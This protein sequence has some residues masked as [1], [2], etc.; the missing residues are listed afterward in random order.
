[1]IAAAAL[2]AWAW[3]LT[4]HGRFWQSGPALPPMLPR[5]APDGAPD[6]AIVVPARDEAALIARSL[7]SLL[8]QDY[9]GR[10]RVILVDDNSHDA[11]A[12]IAHT[13]P[14]ADRLTVIHGRPRPAG[15]AGKL[16]AVHQGVAAS[17]EDLV[18]LTDAD[19]EH[20]PGHLS[21][22]VA[23][24]Q[25][26]GCDMVSEMVRLNTE[27]WA[28]RALI[29]AFVY[30]FQLLYPFAWVNDPLRATAAAAGGTVLIRRTALARIGGIATIADR[31]IDDCALAAR[32]KQGGRIWLGHSDLARSIRPYPGPGDIW[33]MVARSAYVQLHHS[34]LLLLGTLLGLALVFLAPPA[35]AIA[36]EGNARLAGLLGWAG[37][38]ASFLPTLHR[39]GRSRAWAPFLPLVAI[40]YMAATLGAAWS[41]HFG[42]GVAWKGRAYA[43]GRA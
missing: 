23:Q 10:Y 2:L 6:V 19:I 21:S 36:G 31:L 43:A 20:A 37:M 29:P 3:L 7:G 1:M 15:W 13:L 16:W 40:F 9:P 8:A 24:A 14:G 35:L 32:V 12:G 17:T 38:A 39:Y 41:H 18:L 42:R 27:S 4:L 30:F 34:P 25:A 28:E 5:E 11:T 26:T 33:R 22:L